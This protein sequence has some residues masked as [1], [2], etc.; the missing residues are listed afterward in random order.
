MKI[1]KLEELGK[2]LKSYNMP[3]YVVKTPRSEEGVDGRLV[4]FMDKG[5][6]IAEQY[7]VLR[8]NL[9]SLGTE[10]P[11]KTIIIT[12]SQAQEGKTITSSNLAMT[13]ALDQEKKV[14]LVDCDLRRPAIHSIFGLS[15]KPGFSDVLNGVVDIK[16][17]FE[18]PTVGNLYIIPA[19]TIRTSPSEILSSQKLKSILESLRSKFDYVIFD[20]SPVLN[21]TDSSILGS[22]CDAVLFVVRAGVTPR[23]MV[24]EAFNMLVGAQA[25]P[26]ACILTNVHFL[27]DSYYY[28][29]RYKYY[30]YSSEKKDEK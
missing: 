4:S 16:T 27:L 6:Y 28:F 25:R 26:K 30:K 18:K 3:T 20:T 15:R 7:K 11:I 17:F 22:L 14:V 8:T 5:S 19:G 1:L 21:V 12:S 23:N 24:E 10:K 29:Y 9:Y 2:L 13:L